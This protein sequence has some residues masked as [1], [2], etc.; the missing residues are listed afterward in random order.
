MTDD[1]ALRKQLVRHLEGGMAFIPIDRFVRDIPFEKT[2]AKYGGLPY[3]IWQQMYHLYFAQRD[4][5]EF[6]VE[7]DYHGHD[8]PSDYW[9]VSAS[10]ENREEWEHI[11]DRFFSDRIRLKEI[12]MDESSN[13]FSPLPHDPRKNLFREIELVIEH[14]AYHIGQ[15]MLLRRIF[16]NDSPTNLP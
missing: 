14:N 6:S 9:P 5:I 2:G 10:P 7:E 15:L 3:S 12:I 16:E 13:L 11:V 8:W 1:E 4:I